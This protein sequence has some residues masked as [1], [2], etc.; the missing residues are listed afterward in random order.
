MLGARDGAVAVTDG[1]T[2]SIR[3]G[4]SASMCCG[5][6]AGAGHQE[7][8]A[9]QAIQLHAPVAGRGGGLGLGAGANQAETGRWRALDCSGWRGRGLDALWQSG[10]GERGRELDEQVT[11]GHYVTGAEGRHASTSLPT[12]AVSNVSQAL[13][14]LAER[15]RARYA[16]QRAC[17]SSCNCSPPVCVEVQKRESLCLYRCLGPCRAAKDGDS[18]E[19][20]ARKRF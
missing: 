1:L 19:S 14:G 12:P 6:R 5:C 2:G 3:P 17:Q 11:S 16:R 10:N 4:R 8:V 13:S 20:G 15:Q 18:A 9:V 7:L